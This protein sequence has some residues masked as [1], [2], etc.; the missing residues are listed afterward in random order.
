MSSLGKELGDREA[1]GGEPREDVGGL[2]APACASHGEVGF[3]QAADWGEVVADVGSEQARCV[4]EA[5]SASLGFVGE[6]G[7]RM[8]VRR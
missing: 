8:G 6:H 3:A 1:E 7:V 4:G 2:G 5:A